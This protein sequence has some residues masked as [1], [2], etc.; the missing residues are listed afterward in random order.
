MEMG[1]GAAFGYFGGKA[2]AWTINHIRLQWEGLYPVLSIALVLLLFAVCSK[3]H[4][5]GFLAV[6]AAGLV[7]SGSNVLHGR[8][9]LVFHDGLAWL[10]QITMFLTLGLQVYPSQLWA[11]AGAGVLV[12]IFLIAVARPLSVLAALAPFRFGVREKL[13]V[14]WAG[15][16]GAAP[17]I[18][19]TIAVTSGVPH[20]QTI[21]HLVFF[22]AALSVAV[23]GTTLDKMAKWLGVL[24]VGV[25]EKNVPAATAVNSDKQ[26]V[27]FTVAAGSW[28]DGKRVMDL[29]LPKA[30]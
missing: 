18:L 29:R 7:V 3:L 12:A 20:S 16:R 13:F 21:F 30:F 19:A 14:G 11:V 9:L 26:P 27:K 4:G 24:Q 25:T 17:I 15:L 1:L 6:Y 2:L 23:Q 22:V 10:L 5:N 8:S 28:A